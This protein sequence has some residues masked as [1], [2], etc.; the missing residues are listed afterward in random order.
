MSASRLLRQY[1]WPV[2]AGLLAAALILVLFPPAANPPTGETAGPA[3]EA[4]ARDL[5]GPVSYSAAVARAAPSVVNIYTTK[6]VTRPRH[7]LLNDPFFRRFFNSGNFPQQQRMASSLGSGVIV[8]KG[9]YIL[10]NNHV[11]EDADQIVILLFD[12]R[13]ARAEVVG[14]DKDTDLAVLKIDLPELT[15]IAT[16]DPHH[17]RVGDVVLAIGNPFGVGQSV[18]QGI[19]SATGR[20]LGLNT[21]ENFLQTDA[22]IN[23]G[24]S[25]GALID[26]HGNLLGINSAILDETSSVGIGFAI[27]ADTAMRVMAD[28]VKHGR[29]IRGWLGV[30]AQ[31]LAAPAAARMGLDPP[32]GLMI[33]DIHINGPAHLAG[34]IP[35]DIITHINGQL[36]GDGRQGTNIIADLMPGDTIHVDVV[37]NGEKISITAVAGTRPTPG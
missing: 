4:S 33:T 30:Q 35:G 8:D 9:G 18:S 24:N 28:I 17:A 15:P 34:L 29:V 1:G 25:G 31:Q 19:L 32:R 23:P 20:G 36:V 5:E 26:A 2:A 12:G 10:T 11:V 22:A 21:F 16:G 37:R 14:T 3:P 7:P 6:S 27:P 13:E